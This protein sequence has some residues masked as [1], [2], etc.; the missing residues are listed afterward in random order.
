MPELK[1]TSYPDWATDD[2][3]LPVAGTDNKIPPRAIMQTQGA[4]RG[5]FFGCEEAN[6]ILNSNGIWTRYLDQ[7]TQHMKDT[8]L[9]EY[10]TVAA[11][12]ADELLEVGD[13][14]RT[15]GYHT[16][17]DTGGAIYKVST[18]AGTVDGMTL[19][20]LDN[21]LRAEFVYTSNTY[22][23]MQFG[24]LGNGAADDSVPMQKLADLLE[25]NPSETNLQGGVVIDLHGRTYK[26]KI[27]AQ[28]R[29]TLRNGVLKQVAADDNIVEHIE[30]STISDGWDLLHISGV[31]FDGNSMSGTITT[32]ESDGTYT[33]NTNNIGVCLEVNNS[34]PS[35]EYKVVVDGCTF[36]ENAGG[37]IY[38]INKTVSTTSDSIS[39]SSTEFKRVTNIPSSNQG[40]YFLYDTASVVRDPWVFTKCKADIRSQGFGYTTESFIT[41]SGC[42]IDSYLIIADSHFL[43]GTSKCSF[44]NTNIIVDGSGYFTDR[45]Y[46]I[47]FKGGDVTGAICR[48]TFY[49][50]NNLMYLKATDTTF[51]SFGIE[52]V[53]N[54]SVS[55]RPPTHL[56]IQGCRFNSDL[57]T[58]INPNYTNET[59][60]PSVTDRD[61]LNITSCNFK[62]NPYLSI[63]VAATYLTLTSNQM[64]SGGL[65]V[66]GPI[67]D[68][69]TAGVSAVVSN[70]QIITASGFNLIETVELNV[71]TNTYYGICGNLL[72]GA[73]PVMVYVLASTADSTTL[74]YNYNA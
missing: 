55:S 52:R 42:D 47:T 31:T 51:N 28:N 65:S 59:T 25:D 45:D 5:N 9:R 56:D 16:F 4:D 19:I 43:N 53:G 12:V 29:L 22:S 26:A 30:G 49:N 39:V 3:T 46:Q 8:N 58:D 73:N 27:V 64:T 62:K 24:A 15:L 66:S 37:G 71:D 61:L 20:A 2:V 34:D 7:E 68:I 13:Y 10:N 33:L 1:P 17:G 18:A 36:L 23:P 67:V 32:A 70:N 41:F 57:G 35:K 21:G 6:W 48:S 40:I 69:L 50:T 60:L 72:I 63:E 11:M 54:G 44:E 14:V 74:P 38:Y